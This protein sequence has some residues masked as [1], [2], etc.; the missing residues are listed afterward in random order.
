M[1]C[2]VAACACSSVSVKSCPALLAQNLR[3]LAQGLN[4]LPCSLLAA[5]MQLH[6]LYEVCCSS[7]TV[8]AD[9]MHSKPISHCASQKCVPCSTDVAT[10]PLICLP[11]AS[12]DLLAG[13]LQGAFFRVFTYACRGLKGLVDATYASCPSIHAYQNLHGVLFCTHCR[14]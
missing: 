1:L 9:T 5:L 6:W 4:M 2:N 3:S 14:T 13:V 12:T 10:P 7:R 11:C 8:T